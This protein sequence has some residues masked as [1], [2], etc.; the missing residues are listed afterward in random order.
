MTVNRF[1]FAHKYVLLILAFISVVVLGFLTACTTLVKPAVPAEPEVRNVDSIM[2]DVVEVE[3]VSD[4]GK[5]DHIV[6]TTSGSFVVMFGGSGSCPPMVDDVI[7]DDV[8]NRLSIIMFEY[9]P[10]TM[11]TMDYR[12]YFYEVSLTD[13]V[14]REGTVFQ[15]CLRDE[16]FVL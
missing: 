13:D 7:F 15:V 1:S 12:Q 6:S 4:L 8:K 11:C 3:R 14:I 9:P 2:V 16:C 5:I 10:D